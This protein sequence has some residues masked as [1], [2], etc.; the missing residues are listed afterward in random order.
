M[1]YLLWWQCN[2]LFLI[3]VPLCLCCITSWVY[4]ACT[5]GYFIHVNLIS[6]C[7]MWKM[8]VYLWCEVWDAGYHWRIRVDDDHRPGLMVSWAQVEDKEDFLEID[9]HG[10]QGGSVWVNH[11]FMHLMIIYHLL[12]S[13]YKYISHKFHFALIIK[14]GMNMAID[15]IELVSNLWFL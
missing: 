6:I 13:S 14:K 3:V 1:V 10:V 11:A 8:H 9:D 15:L 2:K 4:Y 12:L 5:V 7:H